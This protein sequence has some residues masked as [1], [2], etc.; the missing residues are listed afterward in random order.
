[1]D[2]NGVFRTEHLRD[3]KSKPE[4]ENADCL[5]EE[6]MMETKILR[7][8]EQKKQNPSEFRIKNTKKKEQ[9]LGRKCV[10]LQAKKFKWVFLFFFLNFVWIAL[11]SQNVRRIKRERE[12]EGLKIVIKLWKLQRIWSFSGREM[13]ATENIL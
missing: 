2:G 9:K 6:I 13:V 1:M 11:K 10:N 7:N 3:R 4:T 8:S 12:R 5:T